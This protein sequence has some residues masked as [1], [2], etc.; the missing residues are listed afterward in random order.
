MIEIGLVRS[1]CNASS[2]LH[3]YYLGYYLER[4]PK[5]SYKARFRPYQLLDPI[6]NEWIAV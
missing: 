2:D 6:S 1:I 5:L 3:H 4:C